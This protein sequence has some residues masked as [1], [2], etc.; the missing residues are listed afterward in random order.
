MPW[1]SGPLGLIYRKDLLDKA[2]IKTPIKTWDEF[3]AAAIKYHKAN[4]KSYL[5]NLPGGQTGQWLGL[6]W[7]NG[8][9]PFTSDPN[10]VKVDLTDPKIKQ[11]TEYWDKLYNAG[12]ISHDADFN[13][14]WYQ[15]F[16]KGKYAGWLSAAW[17]PIFLQDYTKNSKG[18]WRA[19]ELPQWN[20][21]DTVSGNWGGSTLAVLQASKHKAAATEFA[22]WI[23]QEKQPVEMF[24]FERFLFPPQNS[25]LKNPTVADQEV[26]VLRRPAGQQGLRPDG[27]RRGQGLGVGSDP[28]VRRH[29]GRRH[30]G[31]VRRPGQGRHGG[32]AA[33]AGRRRQLRQA[34]GPDGRRPVDHP[35]GPRRRRGP[36]RPLSYDMSDATVNH[37]LARHAR[38]GRAREAEGRSPARHSPAS[39]SRRRSW[40]C[41]CSL[42]IAPLVY[43]LYLSLF[44]EQ[45]VGGNSFVGHRQL[46]RRASRTRR[47][48]TASSAWRC[49]WSIQV[50]IM[51]I[52]A[53]VFALI[54]DSGRVWLAKLFRVGF[55]VPYAVPMVIAA[56]MWGYL[57]GKDFGPFADIADK[58]GAAPPNFLER[59]ARCCSRSPT[60]RR[61]RTRATT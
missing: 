14:A 46:R 20:E 17:G 61:G 4:P 29:H 27:E 8:A 15:G 59:A 38:A 50:P 34:A 9:R 32:P 23:L 1:D 45:L 36:L 33:V 60:S 22:R 47:S 2:G 49:S 56:L 43:A 57:Y 58:L 13:D 54:I 7:Q 18:K 48:S 55:F 35:R 40:R 41:S 10:N 44:R 5:V 30:Q 42:F 25:M 16:T 11:V 28:R 31:Q 12:A 52:L 51:L 26:P 19:Q 37:L 39:S 21:G 53:L 3:A 6:F 24:S